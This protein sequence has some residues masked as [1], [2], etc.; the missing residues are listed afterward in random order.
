MR[1]SLPSE[2]L[3][4]A[5]EELRLRERRQLLLAATLLL[6]PMAAFSGLIS[7]FSAW[8]RVVMV[9]TEHFYIVSAAALT[10]FAMAVAVGI[11]SVR[12]REPRTFFLAS[13]FLA[14]AGIFS[15]H[16][17][18]TPGAGFAD[19][20]HNSLQISA[21]VSL[22]VGSILFFLATIAPPRRVQTL[23][24]R[25][26]GR[27]MAG[28]IALVLGYI[29][30]NL[31]APHLLDVIPTGGEPAG[32]GHIHGVIDKKTA[33]T[34]LSYLTMVISVVAGSIAA[35]RFAR[36]FAVS[37]SGATAAVAVSAVL[38]VESH[39]IQTF[40]VVWHISWWL[41][42]GM[43]L[44]AFLIPMTVFALTYRR[45]SSLVEIVD[46]LFL[47]ETLAKMEHSF[48][49][50]ISAFVQAIE[51]R[52]PYLRGHMQRVC[53]LAVEIAEELKLPSAVLRATSYAALLHDLGKLGMPAAILH[54]ADRLTDEEFAVLKEHPARGFE[55]IATTPALLPAAP[56]VRW[57]HERLD[58]SG[59]PDCLRAEQIPVE[60]RVIA[61]AD[62]WDALTSDR[63]YR[64]AMSPQE[65]WSVIAAERGVKLD[66]ACV[67]A[68]Q[69]LLHRAG[70][71]STPTSAP[72]HAEAGQLA[73]AG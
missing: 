21:R 51:E 11:A 57:H 10:S 5:A 13:A 73:F 6:M 22:L 38:L 17:L 33:G 8:D 70:T 71:L 2:R 20:I 41:Y 66:A 32:T 35:W 45:G 58:G 25:H 52:D 12:T 43:L 7:A 64:G 14:I 37:R 48:P 61:V 63:V 49:E 65:A 27:L 28:M 31:A 23:L 39:I 54:K 46:S 42:H 24:E 9:P 36:S 16:G 47:S 40:G 68:L 55:M 50:A 60:A 53:A 3:T 19:T 72:F 67:D 44:I 29:A 1:H 15:V 34:T 30:V 26:H 62:V 59:Y 18:L 4:S 56:A 69:R